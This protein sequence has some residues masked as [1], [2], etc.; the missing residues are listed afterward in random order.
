[1]RIFEVLLTSLSKVVEKRYIL[2]AL[3]VNW[4]KPMTW[5]DK[6]LAKLG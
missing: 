5:K 1:V 4:S 6:R 2:K 3:M